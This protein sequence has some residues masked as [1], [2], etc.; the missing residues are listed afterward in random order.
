MGISARDVDKELGGPPARVLS[1]V[2]LEIADEP[3][4]SLDSVNSDLVIGLLRESNRTLGTTVVM[5]THDPDY[6]RQ[7]DRQLRLADGRLAALEPG[8]A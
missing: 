6:A 2:S 4:G 1:G 3:T 5:V 8:G 7:A